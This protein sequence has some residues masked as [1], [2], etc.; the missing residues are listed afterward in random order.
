MQN[1]TVSI[2][3]E[4]TG[5]R[6]HLTLREIE[7]QHGLFDGGISPKL[8][9]EVVSRPNAVGV[10]PYDPVN[11]IVV[12][13]RQFRIGPWANNDDPW[14]EEIPA[15]LIDEGEALEAVA[16][17]ETAEECG[18][19]VR[20]LAPVSNFYTSP[21]ML[22]E[23]LHLFCGIVEAGPDGSAFGL[24]EEGEDIL[25]NNY[26]WDEFDDKLENGAFQDAKILITG[27]W[28]RGQRDNLR[29]RFL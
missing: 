20:D 17:R 7:L 12:L 5:Y 21:G 11:D 19:N 26:P 13:I 22:S 29:K 2:L 27:L 24:A 15:G 3:G 8:K 6:G 16:C 14:L 9:R 28:L 10:L 1:K 4:K 25:T 23:H 18:C